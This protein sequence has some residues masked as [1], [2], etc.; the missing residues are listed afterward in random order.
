MRKAVFLIFV[1]GLSQF[2]VTVA[3]AQPIPGIHPLDPGGVFQV[4]GMRGLLRG[5]DGHYHAA[6]IS[7]NA[8]RDGSALAFLVAD[9]ALPKDLAE[10]KRFEAAL[11]RCPHTYGFLV[12][13]PAR[14]MLPRQV[15]LTM[16]K[17]GLSLPTLLDDHN[18]FTVSFRHDRRDSPLY[19][20]FDRSEV[21]TIENASTLKQRAPDGET[22]G[23]LM[24]LLDLGK[25]IAPL[26]LQVPN[27][28]PHA[29]KTGI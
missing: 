13:P 28:D 9:P 4:A 1:A 15:M 14:S 25:P 27:K 2:G 19:E 21:L 6:K 22:V 11:K 23:D 26:V 3:R 5:T 7:L 12:I 29:P 24:R 17:T 20:L 16:D 10:A 18:V 8:T